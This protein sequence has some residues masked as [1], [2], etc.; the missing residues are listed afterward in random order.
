MITELQI[1]KVGEP[2]FNMGLSMIGIARKPIKS[3]NM[4]QLKRGESCLTLLT[5][6]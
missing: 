6:W 4:I 3:H 1:L 2:T 5:L